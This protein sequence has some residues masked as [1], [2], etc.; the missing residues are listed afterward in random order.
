VR[1]SYLVVLLFFIF[2]T[3][4]T[5]EIKSGT[6]VPYYVSLKS[7]KI[8]AHVGPGKDY[9][10]KYVYIQKGLPVAVVAKYDTWR[11]IKDPDGEEGWMH[12]SLLSTKRF[13]ISNREALL[14]SHSNDS[15]HV[16]AKITKNVV[17]E[18]K[19][20]R[21]NWI[22][23]SISHSDEKFEGWVKNENVFGI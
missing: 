16:V 21:G 2:S 10:I 18:L 7:N 17:M 20:V 1:H 12:K 22:K 4:I 11:K 8:N 23:V 15:S 6:C 5:A 13:V 14:M 19:A 9:K 3:K